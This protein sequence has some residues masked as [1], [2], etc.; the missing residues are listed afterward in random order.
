MASFAD[1][2]E[3]LAHL[4]L[5]SVPRAC[6]SHPETLLIRAC[7]N[8]WFAD[9]LKQPSADALWITAWSAAKLKRS[10]AATEEQQISQPTSFK[11]KDRLRLAGFVGCMLCGEKG[12][13][14]IYWEFRVRCCKDCLIQHSVADFYLNDY[15]LAPSCFQHLS[16]RQVELHHRCTGTF[17]VNTYWKDSLLPILHLAHNVQETGRNNSSEANV[18][19]AKIAERCEQ[20]QEWCKHDAVDLNSAARCSKTYMRNCNL[21]S[22]LKRNAYEHLLTIIK[23]E[24]QEGQKQ[25][26][27]RQLFEERVAVSRS[28][29]AEQRRQEKDS[30]ANAAA[31]SGKTTET[32]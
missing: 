16:S 24:I 2:P 11:P 13:R 20:L 10:S 4:I 6:A 27:Q 29:A 23:S 19:N 9:K 22:P 31:G 15:G 1:L 30:R 7:T 5:E 25:I 28:M 14:K 17:K 3:P 18:K 32:H 21:A 26:L 12:I 8:K